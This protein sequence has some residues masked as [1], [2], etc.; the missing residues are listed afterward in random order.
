MKIETEQLI[1][2]L[3]RNQYVETGA[4]YKIWEL[5]EKAAKEIE[6]LAEYESMYKD[7]CK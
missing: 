4:A 7:L 6:R 5:F 1:S 2:E 3:K